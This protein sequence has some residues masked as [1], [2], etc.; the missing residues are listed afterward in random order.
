[1]DI[2]V[3]QQTYSLSETCTLQHMLDTVLMQSVNGI[4]IAIN[5]QIIAKSNW[6]TH[7]LHPGDNV[8]LIKATQGG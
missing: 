7:Q 6:P 1:M 2:T 4:A 5:Q 3:N 8:I